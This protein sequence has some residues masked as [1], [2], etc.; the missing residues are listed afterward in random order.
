MNILAIQFDFFKK[1]SDPSI[2]LTADTLDFF[3]M[4]CNKVK[5]MPR[6]LPRLHQFGLACKTGRGL[7]PK[8]SHQLRAQQVNDYNS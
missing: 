3:P 8:T 1:E 4:Y 7:A 2:C 6:R 5:L